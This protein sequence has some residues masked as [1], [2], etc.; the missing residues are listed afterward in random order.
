MFSS[1]KILVI[2]DHSLFLEGLT[3]LLDGLSGD[4][5]IVTANTAN[6]AFNILNDHGDFD[7]VL[8]DLALPDMH[9][10]IALKQISKQYALTPVIILSASDSIADVKQAFDLGAMGYISKS[11]KVNAMIE[12]IKQVL[13]G[14]I[15]VPSRFCE[16]LNDSET[17]SAEVNETVKLTPRQLEILSYVVNGCVNKAIARELNL[18]EAT[19]KAHITAIFKALKIRNRSSAVHAVK[20]L[21]IT[22]NR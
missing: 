8:L 10:L 15:Y 2:D 4:V 1:I 13:L 22:L 11:E 3:L 18:S 7:L 17:G 16:Y 20:D 5:D 12:G 14:N 21:G 6:Q 9:G 19:V